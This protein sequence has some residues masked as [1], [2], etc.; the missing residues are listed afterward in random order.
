MFVD[1]RLISNLMVVALWMF[2]AIYI[3]YSPLLSALL[4]YSIFP[5]LFVDLSFKVF[6]F[7]ILTLYLIYMGVCARA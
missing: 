6:T 7:V 2:D 4:A 5:C 3:R 1:V